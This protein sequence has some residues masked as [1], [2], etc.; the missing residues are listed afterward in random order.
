MDELSELEWRTRR[1]RVDPLIGAAGWRVERFDPDRSLAEC[2]NEAIKEYPT[3]AG[4]ADYALN[5]SG[6]DRRRGRS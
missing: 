6:P 4:P 3:E 2:A 1:S 5:F